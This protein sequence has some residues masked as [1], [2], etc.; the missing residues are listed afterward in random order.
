MADK[1]THV[2][3]KAFDEVLGKLLRSKPKP[4]SQ[5]KTKGKRGTKALIPARP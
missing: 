3:K 1:S 2:D 4:K 5:I